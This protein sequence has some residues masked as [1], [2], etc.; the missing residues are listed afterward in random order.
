MG[1]EPSP[2]FFRTTPSTPS[3]TFTW[4]PRE[5]SRPVLYEVAGIK[6]TEKLPKELRSTRFGYE[7]TSVTRK[8]KAEKFRAGTE[9]GKAYLPQTS[10]EIEAL[11]RYRTQYKVEPTKEYS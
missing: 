6:K 8:L 11:Y 10:T 7:D 9:E 2:H 1:T 5:I 4:S 3:R